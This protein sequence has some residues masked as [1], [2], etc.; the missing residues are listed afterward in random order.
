MSQP[1][2]TTF[3]SEH[4]D[5]SKLFTPEVAAFGHFVINKNVYFTVNDSKKPGHLVRV[6][7]PQTSSPFVMTSPFKE[8]NSTDKPW[9]FIVKCTNTSLSTSL[10]QVYSN[11][12]DYLIKHSVEIFG[13]EYTEAQRELVELLCP[14]PIKETKY[15]DQI[16]IKVRQS[17]SWH[18]PSDS[19]YYIPEG[20]PV[21][22]EKKQVL[23]DGKKRKVYSRL[24]LVERKDLTDVTTQTVVAPSKIDSFDKLCTYINPSREAFYAFDITISKPQDKVWISFNLHQACVTTEETDDDIESS[25]F[26]APACLVDDTVDDP[27]DDTVVEEND[28]DEVEDIEE[29]DEDDVDEEEDDEEDDDDDDDEVVE[30]S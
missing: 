5:T 23:F 24:S 27:V 25:C 10:K 21:S 6:V 15:G 20:V 4:H 2:T 26:G 13:K 12:I 19:K 1:K 9:S 29:V 18:L 17:N 14:T 22:G 8:P 28:V 7:T 3:H 16:K 11:F 30:A